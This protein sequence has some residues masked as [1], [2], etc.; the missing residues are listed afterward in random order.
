MQLFDSGLGPRPGDLPSTGVLRV[1]IIADFVCPWCYIGKRRLDKA[2]QAV[3]GPQVLKWFPYQL[4]PEIPDEGMPLEDYLASRFGSPEAVAPGLAALTRAGRSEGIDFQFDKI[5]RVPNTLDAHR[6]MHLADSA[7]ADTSAIADALLTGFFSRGEDISDRDLLTAIGEKHG[8][9]IG[10]IHDA[11]N[12][13]ESR[14]VVLG[15]EEQVRKRG[16]AGAPIFLVN[17]RLFISGAQP[18]ETLVAAFDRAMFGDEGG[19]PEHTA[20]H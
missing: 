7:Q 15:Q 4:N 12:G 20:L 8:L 2:L 9:G 18:A 19:W 14:A 5:R 16:V 17:Q 11:L 6:L 13:D 1:D 3:R 10:E